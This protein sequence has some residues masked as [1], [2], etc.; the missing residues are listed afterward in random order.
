MNICI[1]LC[2]VVAHLPLPLTLYISPF[3]L[4]LPRQLL[5][6]NFPLMFHFPVIP[7][8]IASHFT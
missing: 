2:S 3:H 8:T 5:H 7:H 6:Y 1:R 4:F